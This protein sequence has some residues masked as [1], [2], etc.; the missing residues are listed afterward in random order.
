MSATKDRN[1]LLIVSDQ[2]KADVAGC[3]GN[4]VARTPNLDRLA[5]L[6]V[7][8]GRAYCPSPL[9][10][11]SRGAMMTGTHC[12]TCG[13]VTQKTP[14]RMDLPTIG[15]MLRDAGYATAAYGKM[16]IVG[17]DQDHDLGFSERGLRIFTHTIHNYADV[18]P[19]D[20]RRKYWAGGDG[21]WDK[22]NYNP[23]NRPIDMAE[24]DLLDTMTAARGIGFL[25]EHRNDRFCLYIGLEKPH[26]D[27]YAPPAY[28]ALYRPEDMP[29]P[30]DWNRR[31]EGV[32]ASMR[33]R[34]EYLESAE[35]TE[36]EARGCMA[37]YYANVSYIDAQIGRLLEALERLA[38][39]ERTLIVYASD[40]GEALFDNGWLQKHCFMEPVVRVPLMMAG[41]GR[42][43]P[44]TVQPG[45]VNLIDLFPTL[46]DL[47][48]LEPPEG[49]EGKS[50]LPLIAAR[51][52][53]QGRETYS[54]YYWTC[55]PSRMVRTDHWKYIHTEGEAP[56]LYDMLRDPREHVNL[57]A[58]PGHAGLCAH[59]KG[60][61]MDGW[62]IPE[63]DIELTAIESR[64]RQKA[65]W[66]A[67][68]AR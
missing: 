31:L 49:L 32:P 42:L 2:H 36:A 53:V 57:A 51:E 61:V 28:H 66:E 9:C 10:A 60:R 54:E 38:L 13:A 65:R 5:S 56:Q 29:L 25:R 8:F 46:A 33:R 59:L 50:L 37:A 15:T 35:Y 67:N 41:S 45:I 16:H 17:E 27:W 58:Q 6:G 1:L 48:G 63:L 12:H 14:L 30:Q 4:P 68:R 18:L 7:R 23:W 47:L 44:G 3:Y 64:Y 55:S 22:R 62:E 34:Q 24:E 39:T 11:P 43:P 21:E 52:P 40:H 20:R 19:E 26:P